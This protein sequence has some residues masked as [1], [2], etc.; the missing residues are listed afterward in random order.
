MYA[1]VIVDIAAAEVDRIFDYDCGS[2][3]IRR[4]VRVTV[5]FGRMNVEGFV[6]GLKER[7]DVPPD[8]IKT[9]REVIDR[10]PIITDEMFGLMDHMVGKMHLLK[11]DVLRLFIPAAMRGGRV[12]ELTRQ[13][14]RLADEYRDRDPNDFIKK[15]ALAQ[16]EVFEYL[17]TEK[18]EGELV[19]ELTR[20]L[21]ASALRNLAD[22]GIVKITDEEQIRVPYSDIRPESAVRV[23]PTAEQRA[24][25]E[26][27]CASHG[28]TFVL[29]GVT[30]SGKT[31]VYM[32]C[33]ERVL[34]Q[35]KTAI[36]LVPEIS[37]TPQVLRNFRARFGDTVA[38]LHSALGQG[39]K[40]DEW[41]KCLSGEARV[42]LGA[43]SA[44]FAPVKNVGLIVIDEE[45][46]QSYISDRAPRY[47]T[48]LVAEWR[49]KYNDADLILGS[50]TPSVET[51]YAA[52]TG[53]Y[54]LLE[55]TGRV[56]GRPLPEV[57]IVDMRK[58]VIAGNN[59]L[60]SGELKAELDK[61][62]K[63]GNQ[64]MLFLNRRGYASF[65]MC[66]ACG[67]VAKCER[68][69]VSLVYHREEN[70]LK[71]HYCGNMY[72]PL[73][74]CPK[75]GSPF[76]KEGYVGTE[77]IAAQL[78]KMYPGVGV[79]RMDNDSTRTKG[80]H[81]RILGEFGAKRAQILVGT[82][83]IAKGHDF[84][85]VTLVGIL[86][87]DMSLHM[88]DYR[89]VERTFQLTTQVAGRAGR[90]ALGGKVILQTYAP[91]HYVYEYVR[92]G[93]YKGFYEKEI[94]LREVTKYPPFAT[95]MRVLVSGSDDAKAASVLKSVYERVCALRDAAPDKFIYLA[96]MRAPLKKI[97]DE[98]RMQILVRLV[99]GNDTDDI[100]D[101]IYRI[102]DECRVPK[103]T[104]YAEVNPVKLS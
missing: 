80:A 55:L 101:G 35:G 50:A 76:M 39:E 103:V 14:A 56:N 6:I 36:M 11:V 19:S 45:H 87:A 71:C 27:V 96:Y 57:R 92:K 104:S 90:A 100:V 40:F 61:C 91:K 48:A 65:V 9:V 34:E 73:E 69:D 46:D 42:V 49:K 37:L 3:D 2:L 1:E 20:I 58:E 52:K 63:E 68:C 43:R 95:I 72:E 16:H 82:Q 28:K 38:I 59:T 89:S 15:N 17:L 5:P 33:I 74:V 18:P 78:T 98:Y 41:R 54:E 31:E 47:S 13:V 4:G 53:K 70:R 23:T 77:K 84:P 66:K 60:F 24:A 88:A 10:A 85:D 22:R 81:A 7:T 51:Y 97:M 99:N 94:N 21:S 12:K 32:E 8:K 102:V 25:V 93:D 64:A 62:V 67:Y 26:R 79:L 44:I 83:M 86:D 30:G 29:H 75:C